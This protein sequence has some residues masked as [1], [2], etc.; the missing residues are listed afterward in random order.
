MR[1]LRTR[2]GRRLPATVLAVAAALLVLS[3]TARSAV[4]PASDHALP[5]E[6]RRIL[7]SQPLAKAN[8]S[9]QVLDA[10]S[11]AS[12]YAHNPDLM[13]K[14]ASN[15]KLV[16]SAAALSLLRP[17]YTFR[18]WFYATAAPDADGVIHGD[19]YIKGGGSPGLVGEDWWLMAR[20]LR[21]LGV[22]RVEGG[23]VGDDTFFD[24]VERG[25]RWP[26]SSVDN[27]YN[28]PVSALSCFYNAVAVTVRPG[29]PGARPFVFLEPFDGFF[30]VSNTAV[31]SGRGRSLRVS[32]TWNGKR[33]VIQV[34]GRIGPGEQPWTTYKNVENPT[35]YAL[36]AF[37]EA[38]AREHIEITGESR[39][40]VVPKDARLI[41]THESRPLSHLI[42]DMN[43]ES[44]NFMAESVLKT[45][46]AELSGAPGTSAAGAAAVR[47]WLRTLGVKTD[48]I[49]MVDGSGLS[50]ENRISSDALARILLAVHD[51]FQAEPEFVASLPVGGIDGTLDGR[52]VETPAAR[53]IRAKT[54]Y[55]RGVTALSGYALNASGK[56]LVF[57]VIVNGLGDRVWE[58][59]RSVDR[60]C[61]ALVQASLPEPAP[62]AA[63]GG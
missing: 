57:S 49:V 21:A 46:G 47:S 20:R 53:H 10:E 9:V 40:G 8:A 2:A 1:T 63:P 15:L 41:W 56:R 17:E 34:S 59:S 13:L 25:P 19:L 43:K 11:G 3:G 45:I 7:A 51:D 5:A 55:I 16:T 29:A 42:H 36:H 26:S 32:R 18:T 28:A 23:L 58:G 22:A 30:D 6:L 35:L 4:T 12:I 37:R 14:P 54:G 62:P 48:G 27:P 50:P 38:A 60:I 52:M 61:E 33:N 44:N 24:D 39:R 31:T